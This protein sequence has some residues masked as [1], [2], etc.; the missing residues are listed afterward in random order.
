MNVDSMKYKI[1]E[2][3]RNMGIDADCLSHWNQ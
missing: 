3:S 1:R 2:M